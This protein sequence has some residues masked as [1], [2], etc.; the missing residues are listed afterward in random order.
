MQSADRRVDVRQVASYDAEQVRRALDAAVSAIC[1]GWDQLVPRGGTVLLKP[2]FLKAAP[3]AAAV[4]TH[5]EIVRAVARSCLDAGAGRVQVGD[6]PGFGS[7][8]KVAAAS[9]V[10]AVVRELGIELV[11]FSRSAD[12]ATPPGCRHRGFSVARE[13]VEADLVINL[14]KFKTHAMMGLTL[15][16]KNL[17][18]CLVGKQKGRWHFQCGRDHGHFARLLVELAYT[19]APAISILDAIVGMEGNGPGSGTPRPLRYLAVARDMLCLDRVAAAVVGTPPEGVPIFAAAEQLGME[20]ALEAITICGDGFDG[21]GCSDLQPA[22]AMQVE[23]PPFLRPVAALL[24]RYATTRPRID[25]QRCCDCGICV[26][27][28]PAD[29]I[30]R[31]SAGGAVTIRHAACIRCFCC[32]ELCPEGAIS[33]YDA[34][35][36]RLLKRLGL[37]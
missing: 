18:G 34:V 2:N 33:A 15:A 27:S 9:G 23:G 25:P 19:V 22:A 16:V 28:C 5:P 24:R 11:D 36:V 35:G 8:D 31:S 29:A 20:T 3:A 17:Y 6:S 12:L 1:G 10:A 4:T 30:N 21:I 7:A 13:V 37:E 26:A 32:Q 14:P